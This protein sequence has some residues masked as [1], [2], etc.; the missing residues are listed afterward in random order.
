MLFIN[1]DIYGGEAV[2]AI[3]VTYR[4]FIVV[5]IK[6]DDKCVMAM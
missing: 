2:S 4:I 1:Y 6:R 5:A 3:Y